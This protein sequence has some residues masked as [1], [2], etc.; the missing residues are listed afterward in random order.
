MQAEK[1]AE[2]ESILTEK[3]IVKKVLSRLEKNGGINNYIV[4]YN[5]RNALDISSDA[6]HGY[7]IRIIFNEK[8]EIKTIGAGA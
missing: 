7:G 5:G 8:E 4:D 1:P 6:W 3:E 2:G